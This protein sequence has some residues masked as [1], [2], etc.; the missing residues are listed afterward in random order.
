MTAA[1]HPMRSYLQDL[2]DCLNRLQHVSSQFGR[3]GSHNFKYPA[4]CFDRFLNAWQRFQRLDYS[5]SSEQLAQFFNE[6]A[7]CRAMFDERVQRDGYWGNYTVSEAGKKEIVERA[8]RCL[9]ELRSA[10]EE[11]SG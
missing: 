8:S 10:V 6:L 3:N 2:C 5:G 9:V 11:L 1:Q 4:E 7:A